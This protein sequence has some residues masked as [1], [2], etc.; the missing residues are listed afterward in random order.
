VFIPDSIKLVYDDNG[1][2]VTDAESD[3]LL[4]TDQITLYLKDYLTRG[5]SAMIGFK[6]RANGQS[7][8]ATYTGAHLQ[9]VNDKGVASTVLS[10]AG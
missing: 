9:L 8:S 5:I 3:Q 4:E 2:T 7:V 10:R 1:F 6:N